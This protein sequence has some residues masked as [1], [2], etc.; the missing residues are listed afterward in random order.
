MNK[1]DKSLTDR[2]PSKGRFMSLR[3]PSLCFTLAFAA[4]SAQGQN[5]GATVDSLASDLAALT[6]RVAKLEGQIVAADLVGTYAIH[7]IQVELSGGNS[8][9][10]SSYVFVGTV[11]LASD[12]TASLTTAAPSGNTL[13]IGSP[14]SVS[15]FMGSGGGGTSTGA[16]TY[17][18][19]TLTLQGGAPPLAVAAGGRILIGS[20]AN[21][22]DGTN[23]LLIL[24]RLQ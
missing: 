13:S 14:S 6:A 19:G 21:P 7:G 16:W 20:S 11:V 12:G 18:D 24:T 4:L 17:A 23:V 9:Q 10:V 5:S 22:S 1:I 8:P 15:P 3:A 2:L